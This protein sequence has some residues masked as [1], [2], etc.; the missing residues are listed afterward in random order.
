MALA[1]D[2]SVPVTPRAVEQAWP[3]VTQRERCLASL[4][5]DGLLERAGGG[6]ALP[7]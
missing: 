4:L 6:Y 5:D 2:A 1:R 3:D 7:G